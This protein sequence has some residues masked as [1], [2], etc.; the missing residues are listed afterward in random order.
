MAFLLMFIY[1]AVTDFK[2]NYSSFV[3]IRALNVTLS[4]VRGLTMDTVLRAGVRE[5]GTL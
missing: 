5:C 2:S 4:G 3:I 1:V